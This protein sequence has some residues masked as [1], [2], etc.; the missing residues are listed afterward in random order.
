MSRDPRLEAVPAAGPQTPEDRERQRKE[1]KRERREGQPL[2]PWERYRAMA[3]AYKIAQDLVEFADRKVR[4]GLIVIGAINLV[5]FGA[6]LRTETALMIPPSWRPWVLAALG[7]YAIV[8][9]RGVGH[10]LS[11]LRPRI[12]PLKTRL[13]TLRGLHFYDDVLSRELPEYEQSWQGLSM[14]ELCALMAEQ[15]YALAHINRGKFRAL[16]RMYAAIRTMLAMGAGLLVAG[17]ALVFLRAD[18]TGVGPNAATS[19]PAALVGETETDSREYK[20]MLAPE[21][22]ADPR[23]GI[24]AFW[25]LVDAE[26]WPGAHIDLAAVERGVAGGPARRRLLQF[27]DA[28]ARPSDKCRPADPA[29]FLFE[30]FGLV[31]RSRVDVKPRAAGTPFE[32]DS[33]VSRPVELTLKSRAPG[34]VVGTEARR[35]SVRVDAGVAPAD[36]RA[37]LEKDMTVGRTTW[38]QSVSVRLAADQASRL[39]TGRAPL[40]PGVAVPDD[41]AEL[42]S[43]YVAPPLAGVPNRPLTAIAGQSAYEEAWSAP[44]AII[45]P[46]GQ[47]ATMTTSL[48]YSP[49]G[50]LKVVETSW[51][52]QQSTHEPLLAADVVGA[53][54]QLL[55]KMVAA[56]ARGGW[57]DADAPLK[58]AHAL[59]GSGE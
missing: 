28:A 24:V 25:R 15:T 10:A 44:G 56:G 16:E 14:R 8:L 19:A 45:L 18:Q 30:C 6:A 37:K 49:A 32:M 9:V 2:D 13:S 38:G 51:R 29:A 3:D 23:A 35:L 43:V 59:G 4:F 17:V 7:I 31:V 57:F 55:D 58:K 48:W 47:R 36:M 20:M 21:R 27:F 52:L 39:F 46:R 50:E 26:R 42:L 22:F 34:N 40:G 11:A 5:V 41:I 33:A 12:N 53:S 54:E 1:D